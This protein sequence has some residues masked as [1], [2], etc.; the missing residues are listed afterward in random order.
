MDKD[1]DF[2]D[3]Y[4]TFD[5]EIHLSYNGPFDEKVLTYLSNYIKNIIGLRTTVS[6]KLY[7]I[8]IELAQNISFYSYDQVKTNE[9]QIGK[10][11]IVLRECKDHYYLH[12]GNV[13]K[14]EDVYSILDKCEIINSLNRDDLFKR[15]Q[16]RL[17]RGSMGGAHIGLI[18]VALTSA[19]PLDFTVTPISEETSFFGISVKIDISE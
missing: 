18:Q 4:K 14:P 11:I 16:R 8:F 17:P 1:F 7:K 19:N 10:G 3:F 12:T 13:T 6:K 2:F 5:S 9:K 15:E